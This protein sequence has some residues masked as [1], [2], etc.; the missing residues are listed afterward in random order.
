MEI[1]R[2]ESFEIGKLNEFMSECGENLKVGDVLRFDMTD[3]PAAAMAV[4]QE[5]NGMIFCFVD[6]LAD[7]HRLHKSGRYPGWDD[8]ELRGVLNEEI[9]NRFPAELHEY[10]VPFDNGDLLRIPTEM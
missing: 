8:C 3:G 5:E 4:K 1:Y 6:C 10:M 7:K 9:L 2:T